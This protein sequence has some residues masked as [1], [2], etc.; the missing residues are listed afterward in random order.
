MLGMRAPKADS[1][2]VPI[3]SDDILAALLQSRSGRSFKDR[4]D[5]AIFRIFLDTGCRL[6]EA[7]N[8]CFSDIDLDNQVMRVVGKGNKIR[9]TVFG[10]K[11]AQSVDRYLRILDREKPD[12][13]AGVDPLRRT[14]VYGFRPPRGRLRS[15]AG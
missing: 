4:R 6:A 8:L 15:Q 2:P 10:T 11:T 5:T 7:A 3:I 9:T 14:R 1:V 12:Y 13:V